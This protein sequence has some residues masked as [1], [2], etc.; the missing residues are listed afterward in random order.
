MSRWPVKDTGILDTTFNA[1]GMIPGIITS[2]G[3]AGSTAGRDRGMA[4]TIDSANKILVVGQSAN[5][6]GNDG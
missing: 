6:W 3:S 5:S 2:D 4:I 1:A